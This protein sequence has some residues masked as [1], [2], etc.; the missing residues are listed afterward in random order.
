MNSFDKIALRTAVAL[1]KKRLE[2]LSH[3]QLLQ[4]SQAKALKVFKAASR[5]FPAYRDILNAHGITPGSIRTINDFYARVPLI[6]KQLVFGKHRLEDLVTPNTADG[7]SDFFVSSGTSGT[8][9]YGLKTKKELRNIR[10]WTDV[11]LERYFSITRKR[12]LLVNCLP[13]ASRVYSELTKAELGAHAERALAVIKSSRAMFDQFLVVSL[14]HIFFKRLLELGEAQGVRWDELPVYFLT[15]GEPLPEN[16]R[17]YFLSRLPKTQPGET[18][19]VISS[20]GLT[21]L[22][23]NAVFFETPETIL[24]RQE[25][26]KNPW[27]R[28]ALYGDDVISCPPLFCWNPRS[29]FLEIEAGKKIGEIIAT[30]LDGDCVT[31]LV[32]YNLHEKGKI[33]KPRELSWILENF[34]LGHLLP[35][36]PLPIIAFYGRSDEVSRAIQD[37]IYWR[38][39]V[40]C[41]LTANFKAFK[42]SNGKLEKVLFQLNKGHSVN[43]ALVNPLVQDLIKL[44]GEG[45]AVDFIEFSAFP[46]GMDLNFENKFDRAMEKA[47]GAD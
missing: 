1:M 39:D 28:K 8:F 5:K 42:S 27:F 20:G 30:N 11:N 44:F 14:G 45:L 9:S 38:H 37:L 31:P 2:V 6:D 40:A 23:M 34:Q 41:A 15:G 43:P 35:K 24:L 3:E 29:T 18:P 21:E 10:W 16:A 25:A 19:R 4:K 47:S 33:L 12:T 7:L 32:R 13:M 36:L 22:S 26:M 17:Q 46:Y